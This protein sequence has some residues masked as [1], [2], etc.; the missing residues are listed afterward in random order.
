MK[1]LAK[2][3]T[4]VVV[5]H[6]GFDGY[7]MYVRVVNAYKITNGK[8]TYQP[9]E[10]ERVAYYTDETQVAREYMGRI[11]YNVDGYLSDYENLV[12]FSTEVKYKQLK[13]S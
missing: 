4:Y 10:Q 9:M 3:T 12:V 5:M 1:K 2:N 7:N 8:R 13:N 6:K 11:G